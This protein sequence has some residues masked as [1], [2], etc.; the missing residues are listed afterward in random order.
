M[1]A[2]TTV[3]MELL[4]ISQDSGFPRFAIIHRW[5]KR[6]LWLCLSL[7]IALLLETLWGAHAGKPFSFHDLWD[8]KC[9]HEHS[10]IKLGHLCELHRQGCILPQGPQ[11][12]VTRHCHRCLDVTS[13]NYWKCLKTVCTPEPSREPWQTWEVSCLDWYLGLDVSKVQRSTIV[14][15]RWVGAQK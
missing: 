8:S 10:M 11:G 13:R 7:A 6:S 14:E 15:K 5:W 2:S 1:A 3:V 4:A 12:D 9:H